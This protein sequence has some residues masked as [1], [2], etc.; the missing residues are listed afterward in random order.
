MS[1]LNCSSALITQLNTTETVA[2]GAASQNVTDNIVQ[3]LPF[4]NGTGSGQIDQHWEKTSV[5]LAAGATVTYTLSALADLL[6]RTIPLVHVAA[7]AIVV[8]SRTAAD[9]LTVGDPT[10]SLAH[11]FSSHLGGATQSI[12]VFD[13]LVLG[14][15]QTDGYAV[16]SGATDQ[17]LI[18]NSGT[19][20]ITFSIGLIG[21]DV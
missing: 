11:P 19:N 2:L 13:L 18:K 16:G 17:L 5:T 3:T 15:G 14:V 4:A 7:L 12:K 10:A 6:G 20:P 8:T 1:A 21:R 9:F